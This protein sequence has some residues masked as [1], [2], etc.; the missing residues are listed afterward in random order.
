MNADRPSS[1][2][3]RDTTALEAARI[4]R[5]RAEGGE[6]TVS[7][8]LPASLPSHVAGSHTGA[9]MQLLESAMSH[10][11]LSKVDYTKGVV[12]LDI[13]LAFLKPA[14]GRLV[15]V[16]KVTGGGRSVCFCE[17]RLTDAAGDLAAQAMGTLKYRPAEPSPEAKAAN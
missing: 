8:D 4:K 14:S 16:G 17:A 9:M 10:A 15:A 6:A 5:D 2:H 11:A 7:L 3:D 13:S 1:L 12:T